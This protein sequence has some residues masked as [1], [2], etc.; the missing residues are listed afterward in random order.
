MKKR[1]LALA[2]SLLMVTSAIP[3]TAFATDY[4]GI[5]TQASTTDATYPTVVQL[6]AKYN[7]KTE[8]MEERSFYEKGSIDFREEK[9]TWKDEEGN[10]LEFVE[11]QSMIGITLSTELDFG[12]KTKPTTYKYYAYFVPKDPAERQVTLRTFFF[13]YF[14]SAHLKSYGNFSEEHKAQEVATINA[15]ATFDPNAHLEEGYVFDGWY[16]G[17]GDDKVTLPL[18]VT[19]PD[20]LEVYQL[21]FYARWK[22]AEEVKSVDVSVRISGDDLSI[23]DGYSTTDYLTPS[24]MSVQPDS[25]ETVMGDSKVGIDKV[26]AMDAL[27]EGVYYSL[28]D[29][30]M[31][32][33]TISD[34]EIAAVKELLGGTTYNWIKGLYGLDNGSDFSWMYVIGDSAPTKGAGDQAITDGDKLWFFYSDYTYAYRGHFDSDS[35]SM[36][37]SEEKTIN[38][39]AVPVLSEMYGTTMRKTFAG[40]TVKVGD[41]TFTTDSNGNVTVSGLSE[42]TYNL[43]ASWEDDEYGWYLVSPFA[44]LTVSHDSSVNLEPPKPDPVDPEPSN[45]DPIT[46][47][48]NG[49]N[50]EKL[51]SIE[52]MYNDMKGVYSEKTVS[53]SSDEDVN[54]F[55][56]MLAKSSLTGIQKIDNLKVPTDLTKI[57]AQKVA[58]YIIAC[59]NNSVDSKELCKTLASWQCEDGSFTNPNILNKRTGKPNPAQGSEQVWCMMAL[60]ISDYPYNQDKAVEYLMSKQNP[61]HGIGYKEFSDVGTTSWVINLFDLMSGDY[62]EQ[63]D[64]LLVYVNDQYSALVSSNDSSSVSAFISSMRATNEQ[65]KD[66]AK[67]YNESGKFF[68]W[69]TEDSS[70]NDYSTST[71]SQALGD[72]VNGQSIYKTLD[73]AYSVDSSDNTN[74]DPVKPNPEPSK[75]DPVKPD[76]TPVKPDPKPSTPT[77]PSKPSTS[78]T[79]HDTS[80]TEVKKPSLVIKSWSVDSVFLPFNDVSQSWSYDAIKFCYVNGF[81]VGNGDTFN[82]KS[83]LT[84]AQFVQIMYNL[85]GKKTYDLCKLTDVSSDNWFYD[86][87]NWAVANGVVAGY[88]DGTFGAND[89]I[90]RQDMVTIMGRF[91]MVTGKDNNFIDKDSI[92]AYAI[93]YVSYFSENGIISGFSDGSFGPKDYT[94]R[95]QCSVIIFRLAEFLNKAA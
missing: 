19:M 6:Y 41:K 54:V 87:V 10:D 75:P 22:P 34:E 81:M 85:F 61:D 21:T 16:Q 94:T 1:F 56:D 53:N 72:Y 27:V 52:S 90:T 69:G 3:T 13:D 36:K 82:P 78:T 4:G 76:P 8:L 74:P 77:N 33:S 31:D 62:T 58:K 40:A 91:L 57:E 73:E 44:N 55:W 45:P 93:S 80:K 48:D 46:P 20:D 11:W 17:L 50:N 24:T 42:G 51:D 9:P 23:A 26:S 70:K 38:L 18:E 35:Y 84:R 95:E 65:V 64:S 32:P 71:C 43:S 89:K 66:L 79:K 2:L 86:A 37:D 12:P 92:S 25:A 14:D 7:G 47:P 63:I 15:P 67:F 30:D 88:A 83:E 49:G 29:A 5:A 59:A 28:Y 39:Y 68:I 60:E